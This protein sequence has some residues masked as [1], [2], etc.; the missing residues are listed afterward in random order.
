MNVTSDNY[1][2]NDQQKLIDTTKLM[3]HEFKQPVDLQLVEATVKQ[4]EERPNIASQSADEVGHEEQKDAS[5]DNGGKRDK[6]KDND[7]DEDK[8]KLIENQKNVEAMQEF[9]FKE[10]SVEFRKNQSY[11]QCVLNPFDKSG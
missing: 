3:S 9:Y 6:P 7:D 8:K 11:K 4:S 10:R 1:A 2:T 5:H